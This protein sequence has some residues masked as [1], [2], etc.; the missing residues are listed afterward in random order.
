MLRREF[1]TSLASVGAIFGLAKLPSEPVE[2]T[3][4]KP[5]AHAAA[6]TSHAIL[7]QS[8]AVAGFQYHQGK[9]VWA[10]LAPD[11]P[12]ILVR[13]PENRFDPLVIRM[14]WKGQKLEYMPRAEN[15]IAAGLMDR[16]EKL[17][18]CV[19]SLAKD[20][21]LWNRIGMKIQLVS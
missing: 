11:E 4:T 10:E 17:S 3:A 1:V 12:L 18:A 5:D 14:E 19:V 21:N 15:R 6:L 8:C 13:E 16:G 9:S 7:L 2:V 20:E